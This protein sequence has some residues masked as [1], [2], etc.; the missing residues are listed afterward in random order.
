MLSF[1]FMHTTGF[2]SHSDCLLH[3]M[4]PGH[5]ECP[6]RLRAIEDRLISCGLDQVLTRPEFGLAT[7]ADLTLAHDA[8]YI[9]KIFQWDTQ[10]Q[11]DQEDRDYIELD[12]DTR[13]NRGSLQAAL[14]AVGAA[15]AATD[16]VID[17][18][19]ANAFCA[20]RP[21]GHH[22]THKR[23]MGFCIFNNVAIAIKH[24]IERR[25]LK[26]VA[27]IDFD[28]HHG[29]GSE[30]IL[31]SLPE[32]LMVGFY[33]HP[34]Y[35]GIHPDPVAHNMLNVPLKAYTKGDA[36]REMVR[37]VWL[38]RLEAF[39][40]EMVFVSAGFDAHQDDDLAQLMLNVSDYAW[41]T[42]EITALA[43]QHAKGRIVSCLE[44]GYDLH[45]LAASV[46]AHLRGLADL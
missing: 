35:P 19:L 26:R 36:V 28:V 12:A 14:R 31:S 37:N 10:L 24:A 16:A 46:E 29:N 38:P 32:V 9:E 30:D 44:G 6:Q 41:I 3:D 18:K 25:G 21:P 40:P 13:M 39:E 42:R 15:L 34:F 22:A 20:I 7:V 43:A 5:P 11:D 2:Y 23:G 8:S 45:A 4:G 17:G 33:Q 27:L 1:I